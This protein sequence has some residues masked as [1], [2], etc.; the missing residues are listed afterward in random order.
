MGVVGC[1]FFHRV[2]YCFSDAAPQGMWALEV[3]DS[4][5]TVRGGGVNFAALLLMCVFVVPILVAVP[6]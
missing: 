1:S 5:Q 3:H 4:L 6:V 2:L